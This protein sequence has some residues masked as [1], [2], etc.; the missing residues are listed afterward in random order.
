MDIVCPAPDEPV[1]EKTTKRTPTDK[2]PTDKKKKKG[3][4]IKRRSLLYDLGLATRPKEPEKSKTVGIE[5]PQPEVAAIE[6]PQVEVS[7]EIEEAPLVAKT[8]KEEEAVP[9][10]AIEVDI[11]EPET[12]QKKVG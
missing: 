12:P 9:V 10:A 1:E 2:T 11:Q 3:P 6:E 4:K 8:T 7:A 5:E